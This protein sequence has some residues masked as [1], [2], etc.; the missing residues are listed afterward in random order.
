M[1]WCR[2]E[3][4][5]AEFRV[6]IGLLTMEGPRLGQSLE[7]VRGHACHLYISGEG[8]L[9]GE[10]LMVLLSCGTGQAVDGFPSEMAQSHSQ[11]AFS[12]GDEISD[13]FAAIYRVCW[14][15]GACTSAAVFFVEVGL[16]QA[17]GPHGS[18]YGEC[19]LTP[20]P[21]NCTAV[22]TG[23]GLT[24]GDRLAVMHECGQELVHGFSANMVSGAERFL[25]GLLGEGQVV[26]GEYAL[27]WCSDRL[28]GSCVNAT[29]FRAYAGRLTVI[30]TPATHSL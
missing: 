15:R 9:A 2:G 29:D 22:L 13:P 1:C 12:F 16:L 5:S 26:P 19:Q 27:C 18:G 24:A 7:C 3:C 8:L 20:E 11:G 23:V 14:C 25:F 30:P 4:G 17:S 6:P 10:K 21:S 28:G